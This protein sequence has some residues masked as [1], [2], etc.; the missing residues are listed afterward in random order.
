VVLAFCLLGVA[1]TSTLPALSQSG[2][3]ASICTGRISA[4][5][6][7]RVRSCSSLIDS[8]TFDGDQLA[9]LYTSRGS[10]WR[11]QGNLDRALA[12]Q[13]EAVSLKPDSAIVRF[14][15]AVTWQSKQQTDRA[16]SDYSEAIRL[17]PDFAM[18]YKNRG[19]TF[20]AIADYDRAIADY[21]RALRLE[22]Q[23]AEGIARRG[24]A[25]LQKGDP[26]GGNAD[27]RAAREID[28]A[29]I[30]LLFGPRGIAS[31][32]GQGF[33]VR[34]D[35]GVFTALELSGASI[36][37]QTNA[38]SE[39]QLR[40]YFD[41]R[42]MKFL[43][44]T[45]P[46]FDQA[47]QAYDR[48][49]CDVL[50]ASI[51][52]LTA[53]R[54]KLSQPEIHHPLPELFAARSPASAQAPPT[55]AGQQPDPCAPADTH[56]KNAEAAGTAAMYE[57][58]LARFGNCAFAGL[59][60]ARIDALKTKAQAAVQAN[61]PVRTDFWDYKG[62]TLSLAADG[63]KRKFYYI[64]PHAVFR[65]MGVTRGTLF[66][67]GTRAGNSYKGTTYAFSIHCKPLAYGV[68]GNV[69][70]DH[71]K[72]TLVGKV[73]VR[74]SGCQVVTHMDQTM[75]IFFHDKVDNWGASLQ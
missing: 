15:R 21:D 61:P 69:S 7:E 17:A 47:R 8:R 41:T 9:I 42:S 40:K 25:K 1:S 67:D 58:H 30:P 39:Q 23:Y 14:N 44:R 32:M 33:M 56:W 74:D 11:A 18:A 5:A 64:E 72:I 48:R 70:D 27:I 66:F 26:H 46:S 2:D 3:A 36:C 6:E 60:R 10:A 75:E 38:A 43:L 20:F 68:S 4:S 35:L 73:P 13:N 31:S 12:D 54:Q 19:D 49:E 28:P 63:N 29:I 16:I 22:P 71:R 65:N 51:A 59:A 45:F 37:L 50:A 52:D 55:A 57:D 34:K 53:A 62:S 24:L